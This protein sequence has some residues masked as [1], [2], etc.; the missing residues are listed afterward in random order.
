M[1]NFTYKFITLV[2]HSH[3]CTDVLRTSHVTRQKLRAS[4]CVRGINWSQIMKCSF[5]EEAE[6]RKTTKSLRCSHIPECV[7]RVLVDNLAYFPWNRFR[8]R[9]TF[10]QTHSS[11]FIKIEIQFSS[12]VFVF[13]HSCRCS[14]SLARIKWTWMEMTSISHEFND[15]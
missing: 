3:S 4:V 9:R 6:E 12:T 1:S 8:L 13:F 14:L 15:K 7:C 10:V 5:E 2:D 11:Q